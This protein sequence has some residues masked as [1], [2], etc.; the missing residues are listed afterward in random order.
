MRGGFAGA[1]FPLPLLRLA[2]SRSLLLSPLLLLSLLL[3]LLL[4]PFPFLYL[5]PLRLAIALLKS[6]TASDGIGGG[7]RRREGGP[8]GAGFGVC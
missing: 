7:S 5:L 6:I 3:S 2:L 4:L 8:D 1:L